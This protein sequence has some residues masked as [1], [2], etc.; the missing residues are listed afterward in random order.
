VRATVSDI[1]LG[2]DIWDG[3]MGE[4]LDQMLEELSVYN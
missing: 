3:W 2:D 1:K 4:P